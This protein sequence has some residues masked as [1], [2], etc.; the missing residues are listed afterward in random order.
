MTRMKDLPIEATSLWDLNF[1]AESLDQ[2]FVHNTIGSGE[3]SQNMGDE[4]SLIIVQAVVPVVKI[5]GQVDLFCSPERS[6]GSLVH[7]PL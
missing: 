3:E 2:V 5:F 6:F 7:V 4:I 1:T